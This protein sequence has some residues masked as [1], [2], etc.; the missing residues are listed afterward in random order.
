MVLYDDKKELNGLCEGK[1]DEVERSVIDPRIFRFHNTS[2][3]YL[4]TVVSVVTID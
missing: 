1:H 3:P 2:V 4:E